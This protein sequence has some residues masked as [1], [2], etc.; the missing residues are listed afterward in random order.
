MDDLLF[1][2][3][4]LHFGKDTDFRFR[5][6]TNRQGAAT[7][8]LLLLVLLNLAS[9]YLCMKKRSEMFAAPFLFVGSLP[10]PFS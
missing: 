3:Y 9:M 7:M 5:F 8:L 6:Q 10:S 1:L 2:Q 4:G